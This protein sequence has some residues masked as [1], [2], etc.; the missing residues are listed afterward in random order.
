M[1]YNPAFDAGLK[2]DYS[3]T[4]TS[5][6]AYTSNFPVLNHSGEPT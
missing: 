6:L 3:Y 2:A 1:D 5:L 4:T